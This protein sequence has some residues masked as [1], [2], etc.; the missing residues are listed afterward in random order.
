VSIGSCLLTFALIAVVRP[1]AQL[2]GPLQP[3]PRTGLIVGQVIDAGSNTPISGA[4]VEISPQPARVLQTDPFT[5]RRLPP[6]PPAPPARVMTSA[7]GRFVFRA[8]PKG[9]FIVTA[10]KP[11][12]LQGAYGRRR[13]GGE[14]QTLALREGEKVAAARIYLWRHSAVSGVVVDEAGEPA[15]GIQV[16]AM[17]RTIASG[18]RGFDYVG[19][20]GWTDD[21]GIYRIHG[22]LP[23]DYIV[24]AVATQVSVPDSM[25]REVR[26]GGVSTVPLAAMGASTAAGDATAMQ[27]SDALLTLGRSA[28][29]PAPSSD[30]RLFVYPTTFNPDTPN[31]LRA[32]VFT[33]GSGEERSGID[34]HLTPVATRRVSGMLTSADGQVGGIPIRLLAED[35]ENSPLELEVATTVTARSGAFVFPAVPVGSYSI[36]VLKGVPA[37]GLSNITTVIQTGFGATISSAE[38]PSPRLYVDSYSM[39][40]AIVPLT[41]GRDDITN[42]TVTLQTGLRVAGR[43]EFEGMGQKPTGQLL[44]QIPVAFEMTGRLRVPQVTGRFDAAGQFSA[45]GFA[46]GRYLIRVGATPP[47]WFLKAITYSGREVSEAPLDLES[48]DAIGVVFTFTDRPTEMSG[49]VRNAAGTT[50]AGATVIVFPVDAQMWSNSW[51]NPRQFR[52]TRVEPTGAFKISPLPSGGYYVVAIPDEVSRDWQ[53]PASLDALSRVAA[54]V[55]ISEGEQ[56]TQDLRIRD[57]RQ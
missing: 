28:I 15:V 24:A 53:E 19:T 35:V 8:L 16:R 27:V 43:A 31:P 39:R 54:R 47:G 1:A 32:E 4:I 21:R 14:R 9:T 11:G 25:A 50:D 52:S 12:Y 33:L 18:R 34:L 41:V 20:A 26:Q 57:F 55:T 17:V 38:T 6:V 36:R 13:P 49:T 51:L 29:G 7:D 3:D 37:A 30:G 42:L 2:P 56:K 46:G 44:T 10:I 23:G 45:F 48:T 40:W 5:L 22:L